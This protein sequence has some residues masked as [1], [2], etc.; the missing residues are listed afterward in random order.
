MKV[1]RSMGA[2]LAPMADDLLADAD[3]AGRLD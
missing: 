2:A 1:R 3:T